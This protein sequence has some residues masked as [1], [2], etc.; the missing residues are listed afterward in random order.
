L[1]PRKL[2]FQDHSNLFFVFLGVI[3]GQENNDKRSKY[4]S[5]T[6]STQA[7]ISGIKDH[8]SKSLTFPMWLSVVLLCW[9][10]V[11]MWT[12]CLFW[13]SKWVRLRQ[14]GCVRCII[15]THKKHQFSQSSNFQS[16][17]EERSFACFVCAVEICQTLTSLATL[18][19][20]IGNASWVGVHWV[21]FIMFPPTVQWRS[22]WL[23][24]KIFTE[25]L[26]K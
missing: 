4:S 16:L 13:E 2:Q 10:Q 20:T 11:I 3:L 18:F 26:F 12:A 14:E 22:Y 1:G 8:L 23:I 7:G 25:N 5:K 6:T 15:G 17:Y 19:F 9:K 21:G 24:D